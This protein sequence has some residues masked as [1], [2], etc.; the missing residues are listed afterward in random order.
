MASQYLKMSSNT[1]MFKQQSQSIKQLKISN[2]IKRL[3]SQDRFYNVEG[4][5][6][7]S[8]KKNSAAATNVNYVENG[9]MWEKSL[10]QGSSS[11][12]AKEFETPRIKVN[13]E[14]ESEQI[15]RNNFDQ[16]SERLNEAIDQP[17]K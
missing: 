4:K 16:I 7:L 11:K 5:K 17:K 15:Q 12:K 14:A 3:C 13:T 1:N 10:R 9:Y 8:N 6:I 2:S